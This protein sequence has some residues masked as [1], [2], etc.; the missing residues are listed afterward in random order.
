V[1]VPLERVFHSL[2]E[3]HDVLTNA[4][5]RADYDARLP[6]S[7]KVPAP[8]YSKAPSAG[9][10]AKQPAQRKTSRALKAASRTMGAVK[11]PAAK[12]S[13]AKIPAVKAKTQAPPPLAQTRSIRPRAS[14]QPTASPSSEPASAQP[15]S[16]QPASAQPASADGR[17]RRLHAAAQEIGV[18]Q[19]A[20]RLVQAA[21]DALKAD[22][23]IGAANNF[24]LALQYRDDPVLRQKLEAIDEQAKSLRV[25]RSV[26]RGRAAERDGRWADAGEH[27]AN[28]HA[29]RPDAAIAERAA[30][31]F[32]LARG[33]LG[34]AAL[35][36]EQAV[37]L[38]PKNAAYRMTLAEIYLAANR[39]DEADITADG[40]RALAP[41]DARVKKLAAAIAQRK[42]DG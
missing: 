5:R 35:L 29:V 19:R 18:Q 21:E 42:K 26:A 23:P 20:D 12:I 13:A 40:A 9:S 33:D 2:T 30:K 17:L 1:R 22:D 6:P 27:L 14:I 34:R 31:A 10:S 24:R 3:A 32:E 16:A 36:A 4:T 28:A 39:L 41:A 25:E 37:D 38:Q 11:V 15:A 8:R 7:L